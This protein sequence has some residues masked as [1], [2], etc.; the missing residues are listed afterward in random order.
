MQITSL[1]FV[2][3]LSLFSTVSAQLQP[4]WTACAQSCLNSQSL[5][6]CPAGDSDCLCSTSSWVSNVNSCLEQSCFP[7]DVTD[8]SDYLN[9]YCG[10][11]VA[12]DTMP[13]STGSAPSSTSTA[14]PSSCVL[15]STLNPELNAQFVFQ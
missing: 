14:S 6:S 3:S 11:T 7:A 5:G 1:L 12:N 9:E 8:A 2:A 10:F 15:S 13:S 4:S